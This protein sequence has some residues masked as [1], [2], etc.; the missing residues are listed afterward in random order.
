MRET[1]T[2]VREK[3][4]TAVVS[5][6]KR[7]EC[8]KCGLCLFKDGAMSAEFYAYNDA[9]AKKGDKV[10]IE[11]SET[12]KLLGAV[13]VFLVPLFLIGLAVA[14]NY[15][16]IKNEIWILILSAAFIILWYTV[17]AL[18]DKKLKGK[19]AFVSRIIEIASPPEDKKTED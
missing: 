18:S 15:L 8:A 14:I 16:F 9:G 1:G 12:G 5:V 19:K 10:I 3:G 7:E 13:M 11:R 6:E 17:L 2:L 4:E